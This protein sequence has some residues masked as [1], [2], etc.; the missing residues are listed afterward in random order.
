MKPILNSYENQ[1]DTTQKNQRPMSLINKRLKIF[2]RKKQ[3][4]VN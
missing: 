1:A 4:L 2:K 3:P